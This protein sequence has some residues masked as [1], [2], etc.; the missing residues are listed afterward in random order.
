[1]FIGET[2]IS[3]M[4]KDQGVG[5]KERRFFQKI[6]R[7]LFIAPFMPDPAQAV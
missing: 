1:M 3:Q 7:L 4:I 6:T 2:G 5:G